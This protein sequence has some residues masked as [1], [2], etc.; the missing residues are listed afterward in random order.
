MDVDEAEQR[1]RITYADGVSE[2][3]AYPGFGDNA[4]QRVICNKLNVKMLEVIFPGTGAVTE[5]NFCPECRPLRRMDGADSDCLTTEKGGDISRVEEIAFDDFEGFVEKK[6]VKG[7]Q[8]ARWDRSETQVFTNFLGRYGDGMVYPYKEYK[9]PR[10]AKKATFEIDFYE[11]GSWSIADRPSAHRAHT[12]RAR[13]A[14]SGSSLGDSANI[15]IDGEQIELGVFSAEVDEGTFS[16][17]TNHGITWT[18][19][20]LNQ[21]MQI[22]VDDLVAKDQKHR[23][24]IEVPATAGLM[25]DGELRLTLAHTLSG[26]LI[27]GDAFALGDESAAGWDNVRVTIQH[28]CKTKRKKGKSPAEHSSDPKTP[29]PA[30]QPTD[31]PSC[32]SVDAVLV[33]SDTFE[34]SYPLAGWTNGLLE[35]SETTSFTQFLGRY[36][37]DELSPFKTFAVPTNAQ[38]VVVELDFYE[39]DSWKSSEDSET[40]AI[41]LNGFIKIDLGNFAEKLD[42]GS[43]TSSLPNGITFRRDSL[44]APAKLG[45]KKGSLDQK[46]RVKIEIPASTNLYDADGRLKLTLDVDVTS[47]A[48]DKSGG[49]DNIK[50]SY[51]SNCSP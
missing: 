18:C 51:K 38:V 25:T 14:D 41:Y 19:W 16:G 32:N 1:I 9:V 34:G 29:S 11:I 39:I 26:A 17:S 31:L 47:K 36:G 13:K 5:L 20:S 46:H 12:R 33:D 8:N 2:T 6:A 3:F 4:V 10:D 35:S 23:I 27:K 37:R 48:K 50:I 40:A 49:W 22:G 15:Y 44:G 43:M 7:W 45:F 30:P 21:P 24:K 42:E 28:G